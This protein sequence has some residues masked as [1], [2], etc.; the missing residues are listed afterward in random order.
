MQ[1]RLT[2]SKSVKMMKLLQELSQI[3]A[4]LEQVRNKL[5]V[6]RKVSK[7]MYVQL[8]ISLLSTS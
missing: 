3:T 5:R 1:G 7:M 8:S 6:F 4:E 2:K